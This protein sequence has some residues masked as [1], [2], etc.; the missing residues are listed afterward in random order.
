VVRFVATASVEESRYNHAVKE[1]AMNRE[2]IFQG[3]AVGAEEMEV[4]HKLMH[5]LLHQ[6]EA[7]LAGE[8][9]DQVRDLLSRFQ[10]VANLHFM[11]EQSLMR[12]HAYPAYDEHRQEHDELITELGDLSRRIAAGE[13]TTAAS[14]ASK[15]E[16][17]LLNHMNTSDAALETYLEEQG[18]RPHSSLD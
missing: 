10:D 9:H 6:L 2:R 18:I 7:A 16:E 15:L 13:F 14:A 3:K 5:D 1:D 12:L 11:E 17:W 4:E 8:R